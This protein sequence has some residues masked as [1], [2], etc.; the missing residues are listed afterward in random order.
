VQL[1]GILGLNRK[2]VYQWE[3]G[4]RPVPWKR[5]KRV[6]DEHGI[7]W[8]WLLE[9]REPK[10]RPNHDPGKCHPLNRRD[11]NQR[12][13]A[14]FPAASQ[15]EQGRLI[16]VSQG[17]VSYLVNGTLQ[18]PWERL[19]AVVDDKDVTWDWLLEGQDTQF[20]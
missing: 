13:L 3:S 14:L 20:G 1:A 12:Y 19:K 15:E 11:I 16:G 8:D 5:M 17:M 4:T 10:A 7:R 9:G 2:T 18:V 6:I